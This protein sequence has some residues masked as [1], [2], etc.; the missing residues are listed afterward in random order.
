MKDAQHARGVKMKKKLAFCLAW[1]CAAA[2]L[3][4]CGKSPGISI[5]NPEPVDGGRNDYYD[6]SYSETIRST[7]LTD[8]RFSVDG[9]YSLRCSRIEN[10][11]LHYEASGGSYYE[12]D[13]SAFELDFDAEDSGFLQI[14]Q[15]LVTEYELF[16]DNGHITNVAG[17]PDCGGETLSADYK[18]GE[19]IYRSDNSGPLLSKEASDAIYNAFLDFAQE[20]GF[21]FTTEGSNQVIYNDADETYLQGVW[22]GTHFGRNCKVE[23]SGN[24]VRIS[25]DGQCT[26]DCDYVIIDGRVVPDNDEEYPRFNGMSTMIKANEFTLTAHFY[27]NGASSSD[28]LFRK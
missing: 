19:S 15:G 18:S 2:F 28:S 10:G 12:R 14:L 4:G 23:F 7:E 8:F 9:E 5:I 17:L 20:E 16:L 22:E 1:L 24:H 3:G 26:D 13:G 27:E 11:G 21:D 25:I 6:S